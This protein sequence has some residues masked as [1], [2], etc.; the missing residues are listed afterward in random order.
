MYLASYDHPPTAATPFPYQASKLAATTPKKKKGSSSVGPKVHPPAY[1]SVDD[2]LPYNKFHA[3]FGPL[4]IGHLYRFAV[5][6]HEILGAPENEGRGVVFW[7]KPDPRSRANAACI[8]ACYM[9]LIQSWPPHLALAPISQIDPPLMPFRDAGYSQAD[10]GLTVQDV[11]YGVWK[12]KEEGIC[13]LRN[14][15]LEEQVES[16]DLIVIANLFCRYERHERVENGDFNWITP[17]F[18]AFASPQHKPIAKVQRGSPEY[19]LLP[20]SVDEVATSMLP[21]PFKNVLCH[22]K[23]RD[24]G[25]VVRLNSELYSPSYFTALGIQHIDMIFPDGTY[26]EMPIVRKFIKLAHETITK[27][28]KN[29]AVHCKAGLGRTGCLIG[30]YLIYRYGFSANDLIAYMRFMR[31]GMVVGPQQHWLHIYQNDFRQWAWEDQY[32]EKLSLMMPATPNKVRAR[33]QVSTPPQ[34]SQ[35]TQRSALGEINGNDSKAGQTMEDNLPAPTPGQPRKTHRI[36]SPARQRRAVSASFGIAEDQ[37]PA[38]NEVVEIH[39]HSRSQ[40]QLEGESEEEWRLRRLSRR[41]SSKSPAGSSEKKRAV[42]YTTTTTTTTYN[43]G[44]GDDVGEIIMSDVENWTSHDAGLYEGKSS[45]SK[46]ASGRKSGNGSGTIGVVK[47]RTPS[48]RS[49]ESREIKN[50]V[51]KVSGRVASAGNRSRS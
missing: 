15:S 51:R 8:L 49:P 23:E 37:E 28:K 5:E 32:K 14:F 42:S 46:S 45:A 1:F 47:T 24:V 17:N 35:G 3:D 19:N 12:A 39:N 40:G 31:P 43:F 27:H 2:S 33:A 20:H 10:Y 34:N 41:T 44:D 11:V 48:R 30:A 25:L 16:L 29:V 50:G 13:G 21:N 36:H 7:S 9:I 6:L 18:V 4:H 22:F 38:E 26:P